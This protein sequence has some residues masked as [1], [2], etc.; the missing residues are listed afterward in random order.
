[1]DF[2]A[3]RVQLS[4]VRVNMVVLGLDAPW[5]MVGDCRPDD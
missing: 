3:E 2:T 5:P 1:M 4:T